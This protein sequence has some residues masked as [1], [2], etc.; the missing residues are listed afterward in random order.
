M[1]SPYS[2]KIVDHG[3]VCSLL[4]RLSVTSVQCTDSDSAW[5]ALALHRT[6]KRTPASAPAALSRPARSESEERHNSTKDH[7]QL[8]QLTQPWQLPPRH[9]SLPQACATECNNTRLFLGGIC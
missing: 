6:N 8:P 5:Q 1:A 9:S 7:E 3:L 4:T 2:L